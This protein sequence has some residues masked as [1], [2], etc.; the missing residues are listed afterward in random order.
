MFSADNHHYMDV[1]LR[2]ARRGIG[3]VAPNPSVG[4]VIV[5]GGRIIGVGRTHEGGRPHAEAAALSDAG[6]EAKGAD[7][8]VTL[9]PCALPGRDD[10]CAGALVEAGV[11]RVFVGCGDPNP[12]VDGLGIQIMREGGIEV[13]VGLLEEECIASHSG[14]LKKIEQKRPHVTLKIATSADHKIA[15]REGERT[16]ISGALA[17]RYL[18]L[19]RSQ[20]DAIM[21]GAKT[22]KIDT[23]QLTARLPGFAHEMKRY[24]MGEVEAPGFEVIAHG[25]IAKALEDMAEQGVTRLLVEGGAKLHQSFLE[26]GFVDEFLWCRSPEEIGAQGVDASYVS[27]LGQYQLEK[28]GERSLGEDRLEIYA[29][30]T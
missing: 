24:V 22:F 15:A 30:D 19:V 7:V 12:R 26:S 17:S 4:C 1:A 21:V 28:S 29:R 18:H 13:L 9:E 14:F 10:P 5:K 27:T 3:R 6:V 25:D 23:P 16:Q 2:L 11:A 8:Y 20:H